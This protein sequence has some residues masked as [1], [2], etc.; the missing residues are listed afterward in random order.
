MRIG[1][2]EQL[3]HNHMLLWLL[4]IASIPVGVAGLLFN[5]QAEGAWR[6]PFVIGTML[7]AIGVLMCWRKTRRASSAT[8]RPWAPGRAV[9]RTGAGAGRGSGGF[10]QRHHH[11]RRLFRNLDRHRGRALFFPAFPRP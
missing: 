9:H 2:D 10:A 3:K 6:N 5:K 11:Q 7:I 8:C 4:A 1:H